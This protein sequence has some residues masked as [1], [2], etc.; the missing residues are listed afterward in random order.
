MSAHQ[1]YQTDS[2]GITLGFVIGA[3]NRLGGDIHGGVKAERTGYHVNIIVD[4]FGNADHTD[5]EPPLQD[6]LF[7][8][9]VLYGPGIAAVEWFDR[10][11]PAAGDDA[12]R[13]VL[14]YADGDHRTIRLEAHGTR[15][16]AWLRRALDV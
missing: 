10:L 5:F 9:D 3:N 1:F 4:G 15:H 2:V 16:E 12:L 6:A 13:V 14:R 7:L 11:L 8:R